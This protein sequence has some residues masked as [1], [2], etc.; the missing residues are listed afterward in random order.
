MVVE[1]SGG[2]KRED[3][4]KEEKGRKQARMKKIKMPGDHIS[5]I[6]GTERDER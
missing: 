2:G 5:R 6:E 3:E 4:K 1:G